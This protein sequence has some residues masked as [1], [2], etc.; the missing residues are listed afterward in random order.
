MKNY[1]T[2]PSKDNQTNIHAIEWKP[3]CQVKAVVQIIHGMVEFMDRY[4]RF[5]N[6]LT[7]HGYYVIGHDQLG[8]GQSVKDE[9]AYG[10]FAKN[11]NECLIE[12]IHT[13]QAMTQVR[14]PDVPYFI[15]GHSMGSFLCQEY[16]EKYGENLSGAILMG[17][18][19]YSPAT[20]KSAKALCLSIAQTK[21]WE[22][23]SQV[24]GRVVLGSAN[25]KF[26][27]A[28][29][30][31]DW[32]SK[33]EGIVDAYNAHPW[34]NFDFTVNGYYTLFEAI[35]YAHRHS[36]DIPKELPILLM[37]GKDDPIGN[38]GLGVKRVYDLLKK[39]NIQNVQ[40][41]L[42]DKDRHELLNETNYVQI[43]NDILHWFEDCMEES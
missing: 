9:N 18:G 26:E 16:I 24:L 3:S 27:P 35:E 39:E 19:Y 43:Q 36:D 12:D 2:Y 33:D 31:N 8:H 11:G 28:R 42:Y 34:N 40:F 32:L 41:K 17:T 37:S 29:T 30:K 4:D 7:D 21:G 14:F 13:L 15:L 1:F 22:Y 10:Y 23:R 38:F 6:F 25:K 20:L 5:A